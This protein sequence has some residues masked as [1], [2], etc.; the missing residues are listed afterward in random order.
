MVSKF[1]T[2]IFLAL[3]VTL[4]IAAQT[5]KVSP[6]VQKQMVELMIR[7]GELTRDC[8]AEA[9][10]YQELVTAEYEHYNR[11]RIPEVVVVQKAG[12]IAPGVSYI[13]IYRKLQTGYQK[14]YGPVAGDCLKQKTM[15]NG[16]YD[17]SA[18]VRTGFDKYG[19]VIYKF[20]GRQ[21]RKETS[22]TRTPTNV[23]SKSKPQKNT[24]LSE[25]GLRQQIMRDGLA[26]ELKRCGDM[27]AIGIVSKA[28]DLNNDGQPEV[29]A[30]VSSPC[31]GAR[32]TRAW[33]YRNVGGKLSALLANVGGSLAMGSGS[34]NGFRN[35]LLVSGSYTDVYK[36]SYKYN[37][38]GYRFAGGKRYQR[39]ASGKLVLSKIINP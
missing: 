12:C 6:A 26:D 10:G 20:D 13:W 32:G 25:A 15:T 18:V 29:T 4:N 8:L 34:T 33:I 36:Y 9:G 1:L 17:V 27:T 35:I 14:I 24:P 28:I 21:Y 22:L 31:F 30:V 19:G 11:D 2:S 37:G 3:L 38:N 23:P 16:F 5:G 39:N 7:Q